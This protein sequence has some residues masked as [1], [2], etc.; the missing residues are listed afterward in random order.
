MSSPIILQKEMTSR[1][2]DY[3]SWIPV[4]LK[5]GPDVGTRLVMHVYSTRGT[6]GRDAGATT[7][8]AMVGDRGRRSE[9]ANIGG[10]RLSSL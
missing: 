4:R 10:R 8:T 5:L 3:A 1:F 2:V 7:A 6:T 9:G